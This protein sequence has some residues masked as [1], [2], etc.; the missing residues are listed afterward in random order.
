MKPKVLIIDDEADVIKYL[1][2]VLKSNDFQPYSVNS[3]KDARA[4][5]EKIC[6]DLICLDIM[7]PEETG[8]SFYAKLK[9]D[10][11]YRRIPVIIISGVVQ[12]GDFDFRSYLSD[13]SIRPPEYFMEKPIDV[14]EFIDTIKRLTKTG[15]SLNSERGV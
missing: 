1:T 2:V 5:I 14:K 12:P 13:N 10:K 8:L 9:H 6:P 15:N 3:I 4:G 11:K 7:M